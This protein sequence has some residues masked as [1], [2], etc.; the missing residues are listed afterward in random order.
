[1]RRRNKKQRI[2]S[3]ILAAAMLGS[4][5]LSA[6]YTVLAERNRRRRPVQSSEMSFVQPSP[7]ESGAPDGTGGTPL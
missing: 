1:M 3:G 7:D 4:I 5:L 6:G 2:I